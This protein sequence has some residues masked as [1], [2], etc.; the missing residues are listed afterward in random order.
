[1]EDRGG[2][3]V[4]G[5]EDDVLEELGGHFET[6]AMGETGEKRVHEGLGKR[7]VDA[8]D[9]LDDAGVDGAKGPSKEIGLVV[10][11][12]GEGGGPHTCGMSMCVCFASPSF[13]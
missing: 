4:G 11:E 8:A 13:L 3:A 6:G 5:V 10:H 12:R 9:V 7:A 1:M 2:L